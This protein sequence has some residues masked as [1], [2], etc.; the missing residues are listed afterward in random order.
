MDLTAFWQAAFASLPLLLACGMVLA[1]I[2][3]NGWTDAAGAIATAVSSGALREGPAVALAALF[4]LLGVGVMT[5]LCPTVAQTMQELVDFGPHPDAALTALAA[6]LFAV[7]LWATVCWAFGL[8]TSESHGLIAGLTGAALALGQGLSALSP[9]PWAKAALGLV[10]SS[11]AGLLG[12]FLCAALAK[13][14]PFAESSPF[15]RHAQVLGAAAMAFFHGAQDGQKFLALFLLALSM[16][17]AG[18]SGPAPLW[19]IL[20][21]AAL[22]GLGTAFGGGRII[23]TVGVE[24]V[25]LTP[26]QGFGA[27]LAGAICLLIS[28]LWGLPVSTTHVKT[29]A[30][31]GAGRSAGRGE[32]DK[33]TVRE[34]FL[35]WGLTFPACLLL[36]YLAARAALIL[37]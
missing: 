19:L 27:D 17:D 35:A 1:V 31:M 33:S 5:L 23:R 8:P 20:L 29:V 9:T 15:F 3:V 10:F 36:G 22:M 6:A 14:L 4:N 21:C 30:M 18:F 34:L 37:L 11:L 25:R 28:C 24:M 13:R 32:V 12:G 7:L 26:S 2:W 16:H